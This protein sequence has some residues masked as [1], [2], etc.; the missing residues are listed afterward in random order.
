MGTHT[1]FYLATPYTQWPYG[2]EDA[3]R[4]AAY[5]AANLMAKGLVVFS[6]IA[7]SHAVIQFLPKGLQFDHDFWMHNDGPLMQGAGGLIV[8]RAEGWEDSKGIAEEIKRFK[9][10]EKPVF[11]STPLYVS[12]ADRIGP[13]PYATEI[14]EAD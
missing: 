3:A 10:W 6:P 13:S 14:M 1:Y 12:K 2:P 5:E 7:H 9:D 4:M 11:Y 8:V